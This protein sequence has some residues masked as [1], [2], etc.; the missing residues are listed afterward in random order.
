MKIL[1]VSHEMHPNQGSECAMG[2]NLVQA[3][4]EKCQVTV[5]CAQGNQL[6]PENYHKAI[7][8]YFRNNGKPINLSVIYVKQPVWSLRLAKINAKFF[9]VSDGV[10]NRYLFYKALDFWHKEALIKAKEIDKLEDFD[11]VH[12]LTPIS[13]LKPGYMW[14]LNK[15][16]FWGPVGG[17]Y[18]MPFAFSIQLGLKSFIFE[19]IRSLNITIK[20]IFF[21]INYKFVSKCCHVWCISTDE[22][23]FIKKH[24]KKVSLM[25]D[26]APP[27]RIKGKKRFY[28]PTEKLKI[29]WSGRHSSYKA[30]DILIKAI[31]ILRSDNIEVYIL[32][33][34]P[35]T[36]KCKELA[37]SRNLNT[38]IW[39]GQ[40][41]YEDAIDIMNNCHLFIHTSLRE[42][43]SHVIMEALGL[44]MPVICHDVCG[45]SSVVNEDSGFKINFENPQKSVFLFGEKIKYILENPEMLEKLSNGALNRAQELS[46]QSKADVMIEHYKIS[47]TNDK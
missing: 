13:F 20:K 43:A 35:E 22:Y 10:G 37:K 7:E 32:G 23:N 25:V 11:I 41:E 34:G 33:E 18:K 45:M 38:L 1:I 24:N 14:K 47:L 15:P 19:T 27:L 26:S 5:M 3:L 9:N 28:S 2:W 16:F 4:S 31:D 42:A 17:M 36:E 29:C 40:K 21:Y 12:Q 8:E 30:L 46:W 6:S 44:G 39:C